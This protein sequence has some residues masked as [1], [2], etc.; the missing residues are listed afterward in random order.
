MI[1]YYNF[2]KNM[3]CGPNIDAVIT[4]L[5]VTMFA[6]AFRTFYLFAK[7][8]SDPLKAQRGWRTL[9]PM[10]LFSAN[11]LSE[12]G[13]DRRAKLFKSAKFLCLLMVICVFLILTYID[14]C[15]RLL[16]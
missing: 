10:F 9:F 16:A 12:V 2:V 8:S 4:V 11:H 13:L 3:L 1:A 14:I 15:P 7:L 6:L 5:W